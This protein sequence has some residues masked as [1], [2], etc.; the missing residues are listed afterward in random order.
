MPEETTSQ[1]ERQKR[2]AAQQER[3]EAL[4]R[5]QAETLAR[6]QELAKAIGQSFSDGQV[7]ASV[8]D[9]E[10]DKELSGV[11]APAY[12]VN[13]GNPNASHYVHCDEFKQR[14]TTTQG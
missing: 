14:F 11:R 5:Q 7:T 13:F 4:K 9:F 1:T 3:W 10:P 12:L 6:N 2:L 8:V